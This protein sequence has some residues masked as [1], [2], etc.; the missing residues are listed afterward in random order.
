MARTVAIGIQNFEEL[1]QKKYFYIDKTAFIKEWWEGGDSATL[2]T[3]P[4]RFGKTLN[5]SMVEQFFSVDYANRGDLFEGLSIWEDETYRELQGTYPVISLSFANVKEKDYQTTR[6]KI[7]QFL[8]KL[9]AEHSFLLDSGLLYKTDRDYFQRISE[10]MDDSDAS[11]ALYQLSDFLYRYYGKKVIILLDEY[12]T[13]MQEAYVNGFWEEI[14]GFTRSMFNAAFKTNPWMERAI[15]TGITRVSKESIFSDLN[16]LEVVTTTSDKYAVSFGFTEKEVFEALDE[17]GISQEKEQVKH[18]YDGF[19]FGEHKDIYNP[20]SILNFLDKKS[21]KTYWPP[22]DY[23]L[24]VAGSRQMSA[25]SHLARCFRENTSSNSLAGKLLREGNRRIKE[26]FEVLIRG[27]SIRSDI[28]EQIVYNQLDGSERSIWSLLLASGYLKVL[29]YEKY[30]DIPEGKQPQYELALTNLEVKLMFRNMI[31]NWFTEAETDYNDF[32]RAML[33]DDLEA[34]NEYMNR[35]ALRTFSYF[36]TGNSPSGE[37]PERFYHGFVLGLIV[38]LQNRYFI[39]SHQESG[40]GR[41]DVVLEP[42]DTCTDDAIILE[43]KVRNKRREASL[44]DTVQEALQQIEKKQYAQR[45]T[46]RGIPKEHIRSYGFAFQG[47]T[48]LIGET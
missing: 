6:K 12:D 48:V 38:D 3:R 19:I 29:S 34:M 7:C 41:Y 13:P 45:L 25:S 36:D 30:E 43:F 33:E 16:N 47:K 2:I 17:Y 31:R 32:I 1:I 8:T 35:V 26:K 14:V 37:E 21:F 39:T 27:E 11:L 23:Y 5:M 40:F 18:W 28:D 22:E 20:W 15:M 24:Q 46:A 44:E 10:N 9:Y 42:K 4:R